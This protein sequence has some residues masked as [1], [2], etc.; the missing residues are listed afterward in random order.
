M[1][2]YKLILI[3]VLSIVLLYLYN[4]VDSLK[5]DVTELR[6]THTEDIKKMEVL[7]INN[8]KINNMPIVSNLNCADTFCKM[9]TNNIINTN[10]NKEVFENL[11]DV[12]SNIIL[13]SQ[14][15][16][17]VNQDLDVINQE[18]LVKEK[19]TADFSA[20]ENDSDSESNFS[21]S[22]NI[23]VYSNDK[24]V[25]DQEVSSNNLAGKYVNSINVEE[26]TSLAEL[27]DASN[28]NKNDD[29]TS[30]L[31]N[32][33]LNLTPEN[34]I[35]L[36]KTMNLKESN[37]SNTS[38]DQHEEVIDVESLIDKLGAEPLV[39]ENEFQINGIELNNLPSSY[40]EIIDSSN[41]NNEEDNKRAFSESNIEMLK[42]DST[43]INSDLDYEL[44]E[45][46]KD[47]LNETL[48]NI[49][50]PLQLD[51]FNTYKLYD[52]QHL[53]KQNNLTTTKIKNGKVKNKT[54]KELYNELNK[55][56][57]KNN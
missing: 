27:C 17:V 31:T 55:I 15:L 4:K 57:L 7:L 10:K 30:D 44:S 42:V 14:K 19:D 1:I 12:S 48:I 6:K 33:L 54:K 24:K 11:Q 46:D 34:S 5:N 47:N 16:D 45:N 35:D 49:K 26:N 32:E 25:S 8:N 18:T 43:S 9:P 53:A 51:N 38:S 37:K 23:I 41:S 22:E 28:L 29:E 36:S 40:L 52:L 21:T 3:L 2:D 13:E 56:N 39:L 50:G 20:T